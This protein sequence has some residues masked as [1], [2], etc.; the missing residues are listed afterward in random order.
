[1]AK[2]DCQA[3][4]SALTKRAMKD[5]ESKKAIQANRQ[6]KN[7]AEFGRHEHGVDREDS[8]ATSARGASQ[9]DGARAA[10]VENENP[11]VVRGT[12]R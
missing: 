1:M 8:A 10:A 7:A 9:L 4:L 3:K 12:A 2:G 11:H 5:P 6:L